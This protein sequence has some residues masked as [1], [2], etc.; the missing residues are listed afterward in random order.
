MGDAAT[1]AALY[2]RKSSA[3][4]DGNEEQISL[5]LSDGLGDENTPPSVF[6][7]LA[8]VHQEEDEQQEDDQGSKK[9]KVSSTCELGAAL[10]LTAAWQNNQRVIRVEWY[11][12]E[13]EYPNLAG[14]VWLRLA[15]LALWTN[16]ALVWVQPLGDSSTSAAA[17]MSKRDD[18]HANRKASLKNA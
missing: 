16:S 4:T 11:T 3:A 17:A 2:C 8:E 15:S 13:P 14:H 7:L 10:L 6:G 18:N 12:I 5:W 9:E 1:L